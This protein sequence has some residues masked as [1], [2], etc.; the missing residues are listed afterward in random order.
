LNFVINLYNLKRNIILVSVF[1]REKKIM[2]ST[3]KKKEL[4]I[5]NHQTTL[6]MDLYRLVCR[7]W[8]LMDNLDGIVPRSTPQQHLLTR[9]PF[10]PF[11][12]IQKTCSIGWN[13]ETT[14]HFVFFF[15]YILHCPQ[16]LTVFFFPPIALYCPLNYPY[17][18]LLTS[19]RNNLICFVLT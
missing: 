7:L 12:K 14:V 11:L 15:I 6:N 3:D 2:F 5:F 10:C 16:I 18:S 4:L 13:W 19:N 17:S 9:V 1:D 8:W